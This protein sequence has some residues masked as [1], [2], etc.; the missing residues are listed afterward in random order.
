M[1]PSADYKALQVWLRQQSKDLYTSTGKFGFTAADLTTWFQFWADAAAKNATPP[2]DVIHTA[3]AG[4][5]AKQIIE[6]KQG[7][8]SFLWSN[9]LSALAKGTDHE[10]GIAT[11]PGDPKGQWARASMYW[12]AFSGTKHKNTVV[13]IINFLVNDPDAGKLLGAE[14]GLAPNLDIRAAV[15]P[16]LN[17]TDQA[18]VSFETDLAAKFGPTPP[19]PPKGHT[20]VKTLLVAAA[21][22]VQFKKS[23]PEKAAATF[24]EQATSAITV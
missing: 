6:T 18:S 8:T 5:V 14:R 17:K 24:L 2:A 3:N 15:S 7:A 12:S 20:Q 1:D 23:S 10:I 16:T 13:D 9:Q 22:S 21:E 19:V 4:D 11:Y